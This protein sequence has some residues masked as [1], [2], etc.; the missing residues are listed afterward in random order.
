MAKEDDRQERKEA[1]S[2]IRAVIDRIEDG[3]LAV[4]SIGDDGKTQVDLPASL[5][6]EGASDGDHLRISISLDR[7]SHAEAKE[8]VKRLQDEL[9]KQGGTEDK[10]D[11]KL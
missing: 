1:S 4:L 9:R 3:G 7:R 10:K 6:P 8:R 5:L 2:Q 11:F